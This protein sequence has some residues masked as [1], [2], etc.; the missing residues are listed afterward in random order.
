MPKLKPN[1]NK[2]YGLA[3][4]SSVLCIVALFY[5]GVLRN[6][7]QQKVQPK[8]EVSEAAK[9]TEFKEVAAAPEAPK[10]TEAEEMAQKV[11]GLLIL[12]DEENKKISEL[13]KQILDLKN[14]SSLGKDER[15]KSLHPLNVKLDKLLNR[16]TLEK[17]KGTTS[18]FAD[19]KATM[20]KYKGI[21]SSDT[22][23][24]IATYEITDGGEIEKVKNRRE[25]VTAELEERINEVWDD[26]KKLLPTSALKKITYFEPYQ[27]RSG[28]FLD[29][30]RNGD[31]LLGINVDRD[32]ERLPCILYHEYGHL[33]SLHPSQRDGEWGGYE[34]SYEQE[35]FKENSYMKKFYDQ[36]YKYTYDDQNAD[37]KGYLFYLRHRNEFVS[38][39]AAT[40]IYDDFA[41]SF[42]CFMIDE[43][44]ENGREK[45][46]FFEQFP[47]LVELRDQ[48]RALL[49]KNNLH[50][51]RFLI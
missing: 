36:F 49:Q 18:D 19:V 30:D 22:E 48:I 38:I 4:L 41:E 5:S 29:Y 14:N 25:N 17:L 40:N 47:E 51:K 6:D 46:K 35:Q 8:A 44:G 31:T 24:F 23:N 21:L 27:G 3:L 10:L 1:K 11:K 39:Y 43:G 9:G 28:A 50:P 20:K 37:K 2:L 32:L 45:I 26:I 33:I 7:A 16:Y 42:T 15:N 13:V 34:A 12:S